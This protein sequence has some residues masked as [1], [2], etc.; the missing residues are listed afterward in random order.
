MMNINREEFRT[1]TK[2]RKALEIYLAAYAHEVLERATKEYGAVMA[3]T[4][5]DELDFGP[6]RGMRF[7][8]R[9]NDRMKDIKTGRLSVGDILATVGEEM[10]ITLI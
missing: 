2:D 1:I 7:L 8:E 9:F 3:L 6:V 4:L 5:R 10:N